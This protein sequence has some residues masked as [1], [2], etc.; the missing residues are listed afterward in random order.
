MWFACMCFVD[1]LSSQPM[2]KPV[3]VL[4]LIYFRIDAKTVYVVVHTL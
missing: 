2:F 4:S 3:S 1:A